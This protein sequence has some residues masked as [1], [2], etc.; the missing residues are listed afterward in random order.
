M[1]LLNRANK[2]SLC[3]ILPFSECNE[4]LLGYTQKRLCHITYLSPTAINLALVRKKEVY[5][6]TI[7]NIN[8]VKK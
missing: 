2:T 7:Y 3:L 8:M 5:F 1:I 4:E 6:C